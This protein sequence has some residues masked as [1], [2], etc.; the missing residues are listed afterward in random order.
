MS[1]AGRRDAAS[2]A[3]PAH[4]GLVAR[5]DAVSEDELWIGLQTLD[6]TVLAIWSGDDMADTYEPMQDEALAP[7]L[8]LVTTSTSGRP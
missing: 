2:H 8:D 4:I 7:V 5:D 3:A 6:G 1:S